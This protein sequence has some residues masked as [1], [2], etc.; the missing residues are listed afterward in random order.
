METITEKDNHGLLQRAAW[1]TKFPTIEVFCISNCNKK[2][3]R[4]RL[5]SQGKKIFRQ[6]PLKCVQNYIFLFF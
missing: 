4:R 1:K 3:Q 2:L 6:Y 5:L